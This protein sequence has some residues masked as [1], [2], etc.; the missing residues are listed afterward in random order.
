MASY[1]GVAA[2]PDSLQAITGAV[3]ANGTGI[4]QLSAAGVQSVGLG[5]GSSS[6]SNQNSLSIL[7]N[8]QASDVAFPALTAIAGNLQIAN[9]PDLTA[10]NGFGQL[11][12]V[13]GN[14]DLTGD[15]QSV[16][17]PDLNSV[18]GGVNIQSSNPNFQC[19]I[20]S[21]RTNGVIK[22]KGFVCV[23]NIKNPAEGV[24]GA[25]FSANSF[26]PPGTSGGVFL[27]PSGRIGGYFSD[28][29]F[30]LD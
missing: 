23:G 9:N 20:G 29:R 12:N 7:N 16:S 22:G 3:S 13:G 25:N 24:T 6:P 30:G 18:G 2:I 4:T 28:C 19:P 21:D 1:Q 5:S 8:E 26:S 11:A 10:I 14:V 15:F 17:L 27:F